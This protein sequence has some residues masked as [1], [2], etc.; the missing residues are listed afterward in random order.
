MIDTIDSRLFDELL[1]HAKK[2]FEDEMLRMKINNINLFP[3]SDGD[4]ALNILSSLEGIINDGNIDYTTIWSKG[5][6]SSGTILCPYLSTLASFLPLTKNNVVEAFR[7]SYN[8]AYDTPMNPAS[9]TILDYMKGVSEIVEEY[10]VEP[11]SFNLLFNKIVFH[12]PQIFD[13]IRERYI[14]TLEKHY[15]LKIN[16]ILEDLKQK[17]IKDA[18][19]NIPGMEYISKDKIVDSGALALYEI[20]KSWDEVLSSYE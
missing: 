6:G 16:I 10:E 1:I 20:F 11:F 13:N 8:D 9:G 19:N 5:K 7:E 18:N 15:N 12:S 14:Q 3:I 2:R 4:T 17:I